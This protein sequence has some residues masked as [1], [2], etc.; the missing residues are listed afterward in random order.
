MIGGEEILPDS[1][2]GSDASCEYKF[3]WLTNGFQ[4]TK[5]GNR[6][7]LNITFKFENADVVNSFQVK[8]YA[9]EKA[10]HITWGTEVRRLELEV[11]GINSGTG[12]TPHKTLAPTN[13]VFK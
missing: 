8:F 13:V 3:C 10:S 12:A 5:S 2:K 4:P 1:S 11:R 6:D 7:D 9:Q